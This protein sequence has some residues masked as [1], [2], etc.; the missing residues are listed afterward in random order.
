MKKINVIAI[1]IS[2]V[3]CSALLFQ[4]CGGDLKGSGTDDNT[5]SQTG[6]ADDRPVPEY[7]PSRSIPL[8]NKNTVGDSSWSVGG[9]DKFYYETN[10]RATYESTL[11]TVFGRNSKPFLGVLSDNCEGERP[12][13]SGESLELSGFFETYIPETQEKT[14]DPQ[15][16]QVLGCAF[17]RLVLDSAQL[18]NGVPGVDFEIY[19]APAECTPDNDL[20]VVNI[21]GGAGVNPI[22]AKADVESWFNAQIDQVCGPQ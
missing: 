16:P 19:F 13:S 5:A 14:A 3:A 11:V 9:E 17:P 22:Q 4:N 1:F 20:Y 12:L 21:G 8:D 6:N 10:Y 18:V 2:L 7:L 15:N